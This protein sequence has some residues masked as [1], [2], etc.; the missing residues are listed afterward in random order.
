M[1]NLVRSAREEIVADK[2]SVKY[3]YCLSI[4]AGRFPSENNY[5]LAHKSRPTSTLI[6]VIGCLFKSTWEL[7]NLRTSSPT[8]FLPYSTLLLCLISWLRAL[9]DTFLYNMVL[10]YQQLFFTSYVCRERWFRLCSYFSF[11]G[12]DY[13]TFIATISW[14]KREPVC[15]PVITNKLFCL[16]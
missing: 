6:C 14:Q 9:T 3:H 8:P 10:W 13:K 12:V 16:Q 2:R 15:Q 11:F 4:P 1:L 5:S 7:E